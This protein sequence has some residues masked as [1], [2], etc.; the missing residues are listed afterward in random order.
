MG[1][2]LAELPRTVTA[3]LFRY[4]FTDLT[5]GRTVVETLRQ[6]FLSGAS[7][8][9]PFVVTLVVLGVV[10]DFVAGVLSPFARALTLLGLTGGQNGMVAQGLTLAILLGVVFLAGVIAESGPTTGVQRGLGRAMAAV[11]GVGSVY[12]SFDRMSAVMLDSDVQSFREVKL[13]EFPH[14]G[15]YS[16]AF[17][18]SEVR[19]DSASG[20]D[21]EK[22]LV[23]FVPLAPNPVMGGFMVCVPAHRVRDVDMTVQEA[24]Q[25]VVTSGVAMT[26]SLRS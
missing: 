22:M 18:T 3:I 7:I 16:L 12:T 2:H 20:G 15:V 4:L 25:A 8:T 21:G 10:F 6:V 1:W 26:D 24:F 5:A 14:A 23:L 19:D 13:I 9:A 11:P 17:Q